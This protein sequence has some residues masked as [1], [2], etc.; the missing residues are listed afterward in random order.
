M[1][2]VLHR[3]DINGDGDGV[4]DGDVA[5]HHEWHLLYHVQFFHQDFHGGD[6]VHDDDDDVHGD[7]VVLLRRFQWPLQLPILQ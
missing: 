7:D 5:W 1:H 6:D 4:R 3:Q 2:D